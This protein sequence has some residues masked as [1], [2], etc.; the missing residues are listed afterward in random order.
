MGLTHLLIG[1][2]M[3]CGTI[4]VVDP[5]DERLAVAQE[6]GAT[7][8]LNPSRQNVKEEVLALTDGRGTDT[9]V[10]SVG[11]VEAIQTAVDSV[12]KQ[13]VVNIFGGC[14]P[15]SVLALDPNRV[16]YDELWITGTQNANPEHYQRA[17][18][19][20]NHMPQAQSLITHR[21]SID[22]ATQAFAARS[23]MQGLKAVLE[24]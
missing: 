16:H 23:E 2:A 11:N 13:G 22:E 20:L 1:R 5:V 10:A 19:L 24:F 14:P 21:F 17:L 18:E 9:S 6:L 8:T 7:A 3:G 4:V 15:G 12:R